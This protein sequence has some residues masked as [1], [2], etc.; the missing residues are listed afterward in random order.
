M[1]DYP[2][3]LNL[4]EEVE[5]SLKTY[6]DNALLDHQAERGSMI[7]DLIRAQKDYWAKPLT[8]TR[9]FPFKGAAN[10]IIPLTAIA[11]EAVHSRT[12]MQ[13]FPDSQKVNARA[14]LQEWSDVAPK[15]E[16]FLN[17]ELGRIK[18]K[19]NMESAVIEIEKL[20]TGV[21]RADYCKLVKYG[22]QTINGEEQEFPVV[23][24][25][26][27]TADSIP[28]SRFLMPFVSNDPQTAPWC[29]EELSWTEAQIRLHEDSGLFVKGTHDALATHYAQ[30]T[31][32][33]QGNRFEASQQA[34]ENRTPVWPTRINFA[35][36]WLGFQ[37][38][39][40][41]PMREIVVHYHQ[42]SRKLMSVRYNWHKDLRRPYRTGVYFPIEHR[43]TGIGICK[44][45]EQFQKEIT[46]QHR[47]RLDN[48]TMANMRMM[49]ISRLSG[50]GPNEPIFPGKMW[51]LDDMTHMDSIQMGEVYPSAYNNEQQSLLYSQQRTGVN[52]VTL[53][54]PQVGTP[55]TATGDIQ[56]VQEGK[57]KYDYTFSNIK[58]FID[59]ILVDLVCNIQQFG[60]KTLSYYGTKDGMMV[61]QLLTLPEDYI[62]EALVMEVKL[63]DAHDNNINDIQRWTSIAG[64]INQYYT[65]LLQLAMQTGNQQA[66]LAISM[67]AMSAASEAMKQIAE[68][69]QLSN[70]E[71]IVM[72]ELIENGTQQLANTAGSVNQLSQQGGSGNAGVA[73]PATGMA[74][75]QIPPQQS[76]GGSY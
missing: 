48:A 38:V 35:Y 29:G 54:M 62:R 28:L 47:Q 45:N 33:T 55:G 18:F 26:G 71:R 57:K 58:G 73:N 46:T 8:E 32:T 44:Q 53:G 4:G 43:W 15:F 36:L 22:M 51:F 41:G 76:Q 7:D 23:V 34:L 31:S 16:S 68:A 25:Q 10:I 50:Y 40:D 66:V 24:K 12:M 2:R 42:E 61:Q 19:K 72:M 14:K 27:A 56:R 75:T 1:A 30:G 70:I 74:L 52:E 63:A 39:K 67:K 60:P 64:M 5:N 9:T 37:V 69:S 59:E 3:L 17:D 21:G 6:L 11:F 13:L 20:G 49:K 65:S